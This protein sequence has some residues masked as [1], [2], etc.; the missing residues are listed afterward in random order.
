MATTSQLVTISP[1]CKAPSGIKFLPRPRTPPPHPPQSL[2]SDTLPEHN[3][4][5]N[6]LS[7]QSKRYSSH[8]RRGSHYHPGSSPTTSTS[9]C[10]PLTSTHPHLFTPSPTTKRHDWMEEQVLQEC[11][12][13]KMQQQEPVWILSPAAK[14]P[15]CRCVSLSLQPMQRQRDGRGTAPAPP[16]HSASSPAALVVSTVTF[17]EHR[18]SEAKQVRGPRRNEQQGAEPPTFSEGGSC[19]R[20][21]SHQ[22]CSASLS[23][24]ECPPLAGWLSG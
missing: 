24:T 17:S 9:I 1:T 10:P 11:H 21:S 16:Q 5:P 3:C 13:Q 22:G 14:T 19:M 4:A 18:P 6:P 7:P 20:L 8:L 23:K 2:I 15:P 12:T